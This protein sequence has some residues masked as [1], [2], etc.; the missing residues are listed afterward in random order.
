MSVK[1]LWPVEA[2]NAVVLKIYRSALH[3][4]RDHCM[5]LN[6]APKYSKPPVTLY[7][8]FILLAGLVAMCRR[9]CRKADALLGQAIMVQ[10][11]VTNYT[12]QVTEGDK[13]IACF[14]SCV[15]SGANFCIL[16]CTVAFSCETNCRRLQAIS[17]YQVCLHACQAV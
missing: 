1:S 11:L 5:M 2:Q 12:F 15:L 9:H 17:V 10:V 16:C 4:K 6:S 14:K 7:R 13:Q 3:C 8:C